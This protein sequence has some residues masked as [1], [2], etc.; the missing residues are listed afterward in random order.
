MNKKFS[1]LKTY[2]IHALNFFVVLCP[3][4]FVVSLR[5]RSGF[6]V[7]LRSRSGFAVSL[8]MRSG[9]AVGFMVSLRGS[10]GT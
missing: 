4:G 5:S 9:F 8:R 3:C 7:S 1:S 6:V 2:I 10:A